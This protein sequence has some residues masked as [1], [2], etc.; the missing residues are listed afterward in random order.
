MNAV[1]K[2]DPPDPKPAPK[3]RRVPSAPP[4]LVK[5]DPAPAFGGNPR[6]GYIQ[7]EMRER[8]AVVR[9]SPGEW[10]RVWEWRASNGSNLFHSANRAMFEGFERTTRV[11]GTGDARVYALYVRYAP[12]S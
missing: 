3:P 7:R 10:F 12:K 4:P 8:L 1:L 2:M 9:E 5:K 6:R 11:E